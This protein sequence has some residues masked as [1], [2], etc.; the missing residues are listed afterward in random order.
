[1]QRQV[2]LHL[3]VCARCCATLRAYPSCCACLSTRAHAQAR[4]SVD[5]QVLYLAFSAHADAKGILQLLRQAAPRAVMLVHGDKAGIRF[6]ADKVRHP[7]SAH[8][9]RLCASDV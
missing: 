8:V 9:V 3:P 1:M 2:L 4:L 5:L 7:A 6:L